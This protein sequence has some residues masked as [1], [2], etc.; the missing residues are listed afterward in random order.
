[1]LIDDVVGSGG[2]RY[3]FFLYRQPKELDISFL[4]LNN[5]TN[6]N[7]AEFAEKTGLG[8][9]YTGWKRRCWDLT[10]VEKIRLRATTS[11]VNIKHLRKEVDCREI[12]RIGNT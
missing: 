10:N 7:L 8:G 4:D 2:H 1:M 3:I 12:L 9:E 5:R 11:L 6:F